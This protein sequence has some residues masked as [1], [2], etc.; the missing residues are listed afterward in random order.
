MID[1]PICLQN[2]MV[3]YVGMVNTDKGFMKVYRCDRCNRQFYKD[4]TRKDADEIE[5]EV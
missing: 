5:G 3:I 1:C 2:E 4:I